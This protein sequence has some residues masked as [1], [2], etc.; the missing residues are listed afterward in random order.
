MD[1]I[2]LEGAV[3][4]RRN[5]GRLIGI[6]ARITVPNE[7][8]FAQTRRFTSKK[9]S[10]ISTFARARIKKLRLSRDVCV[11]KPHKLVWR[12]T[13]EKAQKVFEL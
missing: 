7:K 12:S 2:L 4:P 9:Q 5:M 10:Q 6:W 8:S 3:V 13:E 11:K 1:H